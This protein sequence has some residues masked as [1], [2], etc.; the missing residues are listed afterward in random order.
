MCS[1]NKC[2]S[3]QIVRSR[4]DSV[5]TVECEHIR[6]VKLEHGQG[7]QVEMDNPLQLNHDKFEQL[8]IP[9]RYR[10]EIDTMLKESRQLI[11]RVF[12]EIFV[13]R[14]MC[15]TQE[16][17][18]GLLHVHLQRKPDTTEELTCQTQNK[19]FYCPC[20]AFQSYTHCIPGSSSTTKP[21]RR[22]VH[23]YICLWSVAS[24]P[25]VAR[26]FPFV[27]NNTANGKSYSQY[28]TSL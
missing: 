2:Y 13:V 9:Q 21:S 24:N 25:I 22:C 19:P 27:F 26:E 8:A 1:Y 12:S 11:Q 15:E 23:F 6:S 16:C 4:S 18:L 28:F 5:S 10:G 17:P 20:T 14:N 3:S 7:V